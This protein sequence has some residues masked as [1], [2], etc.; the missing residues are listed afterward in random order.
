MR[1]ITR[2]HG[3][4]VADD[5]TVDL[6]ECRPHASV[7]PPAKTRDDGQPFLLGLP[8]GLDHGAHARRVDGDGLF[9]ED[10][11]SRGD[12][13]FQLDGAEMGRR[14]EQH[15]VARFDDMLVR[16]DPDKPAL[17]RHLIRAAPPLSWSI[18]S[19]ASRLFSNRS[20]KASPIATS[21]ISGPAFS[22]LRR[23]PGSAAS[24]ADKADPNNAAA[25]RVR[26]GV[27]T[28]LIDQRTAEQSRPGL[29]KVSPG[30]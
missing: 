2:L 30:G 25:S 13:R 4:D 1:V 17:G 23:G 15:D 18:P 3:D 24:A 11:L 16:I 5:A 6:V 29:E 10:V 19:S 21:W 8:A 22:E 12:S 26:P 27:Q 14:A 7:V 20:A 28:D 9:R